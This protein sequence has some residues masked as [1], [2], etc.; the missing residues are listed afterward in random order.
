MSDK[1]VLVV[2]DDFNMCD[3]IKSGLES[4]GYSVMTAHNGVEAIA[5]ARHPN[6]KLIV[7]DALIPK[8]SGFE[9]SEKIKKAINPEV[10]IILLT[11][12]Y[13]QTKFKLKAKKEWGAD[14]FMTKPFDL[15]KLI[16]EVQRLIGAP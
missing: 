11:A 5:N 3:L 10:K 4:V 1:V 15:Q 16:G 6:V 13:K 2:D 12:V 8:I 14:V 9:A 7:M